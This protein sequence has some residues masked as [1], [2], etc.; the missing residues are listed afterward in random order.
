MS[1]I[2]KNLFDATQMKD[3][4]AWNV[5]PVYA[6]AGTTLTMST[7][8]PQSGETPCYFRQPGGNQTSA[9]S[10]Y[11]SHSVSQTV[12][13]DGYVEV[14][15]RL[16]S[17]EDSFANYQWQIELGSTAT[18]YEPYVGGKPS[19]NPEYPQEINSIDNFM[20]HICGKNLFDYPTEPFTNTYSSVYNGYAFSGGFRSIP[21]GVTTITASMYIDNSAATENS[22]LTV[23]VHNSNGV[24]V[25]IGS[26]IINAGATGRV[27]KT[28]DVSNYNDFALGSLIRPGT[29]VSQLMVEL[30]STATDYEPYQG[31]SIDIPLGD[32]QVRSLPDG[33]EDTLTFGYIGPSIRE[34]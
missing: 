21:N 18:D 13:E 31:Q 6:P 32:H 9:N 30:G 17:G 15:Q 34:G 20:L 25:P 23:W 11:S 5:I 8:K 10:V 29:T 1:Y 19:P 28:Y 3:Q 16:A 26:S 33:T 22:A 27:S 4:A 24:V 14:V 12:P 7:N 2:G